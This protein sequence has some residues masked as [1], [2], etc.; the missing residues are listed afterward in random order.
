MDNL[1][2]HYFLLG[3]LVSLKCLAGEYCWEQSQDIS[4]W[5]RNGEVG[6]GRKKIQ[7]QSKETTFQ[8]FGE[9]KSIINTER[10]PEKRIHRKEKTK[11]SHLHQKT[12]RETWADIPERGRPLDLSRRCF[13][14]AL[15]RWK[16]LLQVQ[17]DPA[18]TIT[19][20]KAGFVNQ[21]KISFRQRN[22][23]IKKQY[24]SICC[25]AKEK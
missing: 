21:W 23:S 1:P 18:A 19:V 5:E 11:Q 22:H 12:G 7:Q 20:Q 15:D 3:S 2:F 8:K 13:L 17:G 4:C 16:A 6:T 24:W 25:P 14:W 9:A 10:R